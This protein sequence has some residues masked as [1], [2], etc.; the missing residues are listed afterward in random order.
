[1]LPTKF[2]SHPLF[3][4]IG[5]FFDLAALGIG[6]MLILRIKS[7]RDDIS[8]VTERPE[9]FELDHEAMYIPLGIWSLA[10]LL[11]WFTSNLSVLYWYNWSVGSW[12]PG[13]YLTAEVFLLFIA[14]YILWHPQNNFEWGVESTVLPVKPERLGMELIDRSQ[15]ILPKL[16]KS[17]T[18]GAKPKERCPICGARASFERRAC[19]NCGQP[20]L[21]SWCKVT[22]NYIVTCPNC[23]EPTSYGKVGCIHCGKPIYQTIRCSCGEESEISDWKF[24]HK[25]K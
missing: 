13:P 19:P 5:I 15:K 18:F 25:V 14:I 24:L 8:G 17:V 23:K 9:G 7:I 16:K 1:M 11:F 10:V 3:T 21:F 2:T 22:E 6:V 4:A 12:G 20:R